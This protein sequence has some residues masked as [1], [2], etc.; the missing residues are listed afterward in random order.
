MDYIPFVKAYKKAGENTII[1]LSVGE[2]KKFPVLV[3]DITF[4]PVTDEVAH[5]DFVF[6]DIS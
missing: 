4:D 5:V 6:V 3:H 2:G 1:D